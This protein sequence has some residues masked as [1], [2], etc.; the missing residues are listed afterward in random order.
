MLWGW[1]SDIALIQDGGTWRIK[2]HKP[3]FYFSHYL[4][5]G[6]LE[7]WSLIKKDSQG[8][9]KFSSMASV[10]PTISWEIGL[11]KFLQTLLT[12]SSINSKRGWEFWFPST[13]LLWSFGPLFHIG[14]SFSFSTH[15]ITAPSPLWDGEHRRVKENGFH[16]LAARLLQRGFKLKPWG[17]LPTYW[18]VSKYRFKFMDLL[19]DWCTL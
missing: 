19:L 7:P 10:F 15:S 2:F 9:G 3:K 13:S 1:Q 17:M 18:T 5:L 16:V 4:P 6:T 14:T 11:D 8:I 12:T